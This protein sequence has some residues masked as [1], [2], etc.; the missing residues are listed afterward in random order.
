MFNQ[1]NLNNQ[2]EHTAGGAQRRGSKLVNE[3]R[4]GNDADDKMDGDKA[5][6][7]QSSEYKPAFSVQ[8]EGDGDGDDK[9]G[10]E[11]FFNFHP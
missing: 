6:R 3:K 1:L 9:D 7:V 8:M 11:E 2:C 5:L 10:E 4:G